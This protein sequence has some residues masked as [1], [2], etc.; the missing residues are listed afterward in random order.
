MQVYAD[1]S[2]GGT[3][4]PY[5]YLSG[6]RG[7][8]GSSGLPAALSNASVLSADDTSVAVI[9]SDE[10]VFVY[11]VELGDQSTDGVGTSVV[12]EAEGHY[13]IRGGDAQLVDLLGRE[14]NA[15]L[16]GVGVWS[17]VSLSGA[18][19]LTIEATKPVVVAVG[20]SLDGGEYGVGQVS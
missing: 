5:L 17:D 6:T 18:S 19:S 11:T 7:A 13:A 1:T 3:E 16:P 15:T 20:S 10:I 14:A 8:D 4:G 2:S 9:A 12:L